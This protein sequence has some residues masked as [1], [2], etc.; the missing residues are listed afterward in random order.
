M[1]ALGLAAMEDIEEEVLVQIEAALRESFPVEVIRLA[2]LGPPN[3]EFDA[4]REQ[5]SAPMILKRVLASKPSS[6]DKVLAVTSHDLFIPMLSFVYGQAQLNGVAAVVSLARLRQEFYTM[7]GNKT[8]LLARSRKEAVHETGHL[9]NLVH[10]SEAG[11]AMSLSTNLRQLDLKS[12]TLCPACS[13][14][15]WERFK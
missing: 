15:A 6:V 11:C 5:F 14:L 2:P 9:H 7:P 1:T 8:V 13:A 3:S 12:D 10:C 4:A